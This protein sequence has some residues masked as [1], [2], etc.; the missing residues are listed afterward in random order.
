MARDMHDVVAH[1]LTLLVVHAETVRARSGELP[2][3]ARERLDSLA[4]AGRQ[5]T[6]EMRDLLAVL[7]DGTDTAPL[8]PAPTLSG[9]DA[10]VK[11]A[12]DSGN[13]VTV[14]ADG[15]L[16]DLPRPVQLAAYRIVQEG[17]SNGRRHA[18]GA[19][20][21]LHLRATA[22]RID[23][24]VTSG[25]PPEPVTRMPGSGLGLAGL[26]ERVTALGGELGAGPTPDGG[27]QIIA[28]VPNTHQGHEHAHR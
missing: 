10:L 18:P 6:E 26:T 17:L 9:L 20:V 13:P 27:F 25:A 7:R 15:P 19:R 21:A 23:L 5:A 22:T 16:D 2:P 11:T 1:S 3:W 14:T 28:A 12:R 8:T 24:E 4:A